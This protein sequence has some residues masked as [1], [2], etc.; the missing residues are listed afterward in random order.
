[1]QSDRLRERWEKQ[2]RTDFEEI[3]ALSEERNMEMVPFVVEKAIVK[4]ERFCKKYSG[5]DS[6]ESCL[7]GS[8]VHWFLGHMQM[9]TGH[10]EEAKNNLQESHRL[11]RAGVM[12]ANLLQLQE[13]THKELRA[14]LCIAELSHKTKDYSAALRILV[15]GLGTARKQ[16]FRALEGECLLWI[17]KT[18][19]EQKKLSQTEAKL[20]E[21]FPL[22]S[23]SS[24]SRGIAPVEVYAECHAL[25]VS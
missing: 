10:V 12:D 25:L 14:A 9:N 3:S 18:Y 2:K 7:M 20:R 4:C 1:M 16:D 22:L 17:G 11:A 15:A 21:A 19:M 23:P 13:L 8:Q 5:A 6:A 24:T